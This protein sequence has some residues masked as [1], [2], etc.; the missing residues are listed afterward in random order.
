MSQDGVPCGGQSRTRPLSESLESSTIVFAWIINK[1][2]WRL[3]RL[4]R[5][6]VVVHS[7]QSSEESI[8]LTIL[9]LGFTSG[10]VPIESE[11]GY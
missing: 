2:L 10:K 7:S 6:R 4:W 9:K 5:S 3:W 11:N 8:Q 1:R